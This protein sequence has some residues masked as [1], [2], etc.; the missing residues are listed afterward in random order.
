MR[1]IY[2]LKIALDTRQMYILHAA[3]TWMQTDP[4]SVAAQLLMS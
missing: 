2:R 3:Q 4:Q 1:E